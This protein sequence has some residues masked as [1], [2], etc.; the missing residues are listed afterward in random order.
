MDQYPPIIGLCGKRGAGKNEAAK[1]IR[2][3]MPGVWKE[4]GFADK[5]KEVAALLTG[6]PLETFKTQEGKTTHLPAYDMHV[7]EFLQRLGTDAIRDNLHEQTWINACLSQKLDFSGQRLLITDCRFPNEV[8]AIDAAGGVIIRI[9]GDPLHQRGDGTRNDNHPS[10]IALDHLDL[11]TIHNR[12]NLH[13]L[14]N[15]LVNLLAQ[16][17]NGNRPNATSNWMAFK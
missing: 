7:G 5:V 3:L 10:E 6:L 17:K 8:E 16:L 4:V 2:S 9:E 13:S 15:K 12:G 14:R 11:P 1:I